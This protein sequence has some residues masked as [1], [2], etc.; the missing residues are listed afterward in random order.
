MVPSRG[1]GLRSSEESQ[2]RLLIELKDKHPNSL[3]KHNLVLFHLY[4]TAHRAKPPWTKTCLLLPTV[5]GLLGTTLHRREGPGK[6]YLPSQVARLATVSGIDSKII[7]SR[8]V[9]LPHLRSRQI[10]RCQPHCGP[11]SPKLSSQASNNLSSSS[12]TQWRGP[13]KLRFK[14]ALTKIELSS[15]SWKKWVSRLPTPTR[16]FKVQGSTR[17]KS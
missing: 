2:D 17:A 8:H 15:T 1:L 7:R 4:E 6:S 5:G 3:L 10:G 11:P 12:K 16:C 9:K 13:S 14:L